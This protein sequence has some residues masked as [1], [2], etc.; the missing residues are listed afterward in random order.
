M[1]A[2]ANGKRSQVSGEN[3]FTAIYENSVDKKLMFRILCSANAKIVSKRVKEAFVLA[4]VE[5]TASSITT[6]AGKYFDRVE[7]RQMAVFFVKN[8]FN[9]SWSLLAKCFHYTTH[10]SCLQ[11]Y[12]TI[13][14][15]LE[16]DK[17]L[18]LVYNDFEREA[19][20][21]LDLIF[22]TDIKVLQRVKY[23]LITD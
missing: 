22:Q 15:R 16:V 11:A 7:A 19:N 1:T 9:L 5:K 10:S 13:S 21:E 6:L 20:L 23:N 17:R 3:F 2:I 18:V 14:G 12:R 8:E 4:V